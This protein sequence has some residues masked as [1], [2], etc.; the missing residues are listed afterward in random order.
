MRT[1]ERTVKMDLKL[2]EKN[3]DEVMQKKTEAPKRSGR[4]IA[5]LASLSTL[6][7]EELDE[8]NENVDDNIEYSEDE[9]DDGNEGY[10]E[11]EDTEGEDTETEEEPKEE[12]EPP[13]EHYGRVF[14]FEAIL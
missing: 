5:E 7:K 11:A 3:D 14:S 4:S 10:D 6:S 9:Y 13:M 12:N 8:A 1:S 2:K